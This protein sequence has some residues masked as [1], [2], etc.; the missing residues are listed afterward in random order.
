M[1]VTADVERA[2]AR[3]RPLD[4]FLTKHPGDRAALIDAAGREYSFAQ[5]GSLA[6][7][8]HAATATREKTLIL[9]GTERTLDGAAAYLLTLTSDHAVFPVGGETLARSL[10]DY[11]T[12]WQPEFVLLPTAMAGDAGDALAGC[13]AV[14]D[15]AVPGHVLVRRRD[16]REAS[17]IH[18]DTKLLLR[19]SGTIGTPKIVRLSCRNVLSN[20]ADIAAAIGIADDDRGVTSLPLD[21]S[22]GLSVLHSHLTRGSSLLITSESPEA[23]PFWR[24]AAHR[25]VSIAYTIPSTCRRLLTAGWTPAKAAGLRLICQAG[26]YLSAKAKLD[27]IDRIEPWGVGFAAMYGQTEATARISYLPPTDARERIG[28]V[29]GPLRCGRVRLQQRPGGE[30]EIVFEGPN[31]M[32]GYARARADLRRGDEHGGVLETGDLGSLDAGYL[33]V[34]GR[35]DRMIKLAGRRLQL[36]EIEAWLEPRFGETAAVADEELLHVCAT[37]TV[38]EAAALKRQLAS[39]LAVPP[40]LIALHRFERL[41]RTSTGKTDL[42]QLSSLVLR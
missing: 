6:R 5:L 8:F 33:Y 30:S 20:A 4:V 7:R 28:S 38:G 36:E 9:C 3:E 32:M 29:G 34:H 41:P 19:T 14:D 12:T 31:V 11:L 25:R 21:F 27:L 16:A 2:G 24:H 40:A 18:A 15:A 26:G 42:K 23:G 22:Y 39:Q 1:T 17:P 10:A 13:D 37:G 35:G